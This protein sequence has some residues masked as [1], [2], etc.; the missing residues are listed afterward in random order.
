MRT[1]TFE[2]SA[3]ISYANGSGQQVECNF[4]ELHEPTGKVSHT[5]CAIE[6]MIQS[7]MLEMANKLPA[8]DLDAAKESA[9]AAEPDDDVKDGDGILAVL[10]G[11]GVDMNKLVLHYRELFKVV[12]HMG[13]EKALTGPRMDDMSHS[14]FRKMLGVYTAN[15]ILT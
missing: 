12:A 11:S 4:I 3:P 6:G 1:I 2:L 13:G 10:N 5:C 8:D 9:Q 14:D 7:K 15:F